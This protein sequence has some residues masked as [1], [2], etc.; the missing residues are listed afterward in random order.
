MT[1]TAERQI[2]ELN[3][4][5]EDKSFAGFVEDTLRPGGL[6]LTEE[7]IEKCHLP[8]TAAVLDIG[9]GYGKT[10]KYLRDQWGLQ[11][12][13]VDIAE[14]MIQG[15]LA[16]DSTLNLTAAA[17]DKLP[18]ADQ[19]FDAVTA[20][21]VFCLLPDKAAALRE[22]H[23]V[24]KPCGKFIVSDLYLKKPSAEKISLNAVTCL[25]NLMTEQEI[26]AITEKGGFVKT[27]FED[28]RSDYLGFLAEMIFQFDTVEGFWQWIFGGSCAS[29]CSAADKLKK[30]KISYYAAIW[31]KK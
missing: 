27:N 30:Q 29:S 24:L 12:C 22:I 5:Y 20:E 18:F 15:G 11:A 10:V 2:N 21:C 7:M 23:R 1:N 14:K 26:T 19:T 16:V 13:G 4:L 9:C 6:E 31:Q 8:Q 25:Q 17:A 28:R 3:A